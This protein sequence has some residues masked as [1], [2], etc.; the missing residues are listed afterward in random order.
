MK[1]LFPS[2]MLPLKKWYAFKAK[3]PS[4]SENEHRII[5]IYKHEAVIKYF[6]VTS[7]V[8]KIEKVA[9]TRKYDVESIVKLNPVEWDVL[10]KESCI[11][12]NK[13]HLYEINESD[14]KR[15]YTNGE[16]E[17]LGEIPEKVKAAIIHAICMS[18][19]FTENEKKM[20][21]VD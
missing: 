17:Y 18:I 4:G 5:I 19:S 2:N 9:I 11:Q 3:L 16:F 1:I 20:Y 10:T 12:C 21:T 14:F 7:Q 8:E 13:K 6:Y 15:A